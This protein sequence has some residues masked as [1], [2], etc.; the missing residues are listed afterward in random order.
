[1]CAAASCNRMAL[2]TFCDGHSQRKRKYG[3]VVLPCT[4]CGRD[5]GLDRFPKTTCDDSCDSECA[6][7]GCARAPSVGD[8]CASHEARLRRNA[9]VAEYRAVSAGRSC[10][11]CEKPLGRDPRRMYCSSSCMKFAN[12]H[13]DIQGALW[14][15]CGG[16]GD[17]FSLLETLE[18]KPRRRADVNKCLSCSRRNFHIFRIHRETVIERDGT[19]CALC[20]K[21]ID[22]S[23]TWP[24][25]MSFSIDHVIPWSLGGSH[26]PDNLQPAHLLC[27]ATKQDRVGF[28]IA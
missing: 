8:R 9:L 19:V 20:S 4:T 26:D 27:N 11:V 1:M 15:T 7:P 10:G 5:I 24:H 16:C 2:G 13:A 6:E 14:K 12:A 3:S 21:P 22:M 18:G 25:K 17:Q 23:L 28:T